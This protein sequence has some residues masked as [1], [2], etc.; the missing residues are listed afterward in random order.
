MIDIDIE[1]SLATPLARIKVLG[2]GGAGCNALNSM[3]DGEYEGVEF[4]ATNTDAQALRVCRAP[5][6]LQIGAKSTKGLGTGANPDLGRKAAE[7]DRE[8]ILAALEGAD[9]VFLVGG[10]GGGTGS[11]ALPVIARLLKEKNILTIA[12]VT[13]PFIFEGK[14][15]MITAEKSLG[16]LEKEVDTLVVIPNQWL[17][18][19][20]EKNVS[21]INA[22]GRVNGTIAQCV[23]SVADII[24]R[25]GQINVDFAD[26]RAIM[27]SQGTALMG[28]GRASGAN[29][30]QDATQAAISSSPLEMLSIAGARSV[31]LTLAGSS[32]LGLHEVSIAASIIYESADENAN[33]IMG[34]IID[35]S[36][37]DE[38]VVTIIATGFM[39]KMQEKL[40]DPIAPAARMAAPEYPHMA[41]Q[42]SEPM[43]SAAPAEQLQDP[44][45]IPAILRRL[46][47]ER[48]QRIR[49][50]HNQ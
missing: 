21:L 16:D 15:R 1:S 9:L 14:R 2:V 40:L 35:E 20:E 12:V 19:H 44:L 41:E 26:V 33:I 17:L 47:E 46:R 11:G 30:A 23:R 39:P 49:S 18:D 13:K 37:G 7:E 5:M 4:I 31:L 25:P 27:K 10:L 50:S 36:L 45:E 43:I 32:S 42:P 29:R 28:I 22:F 24:A 34:T 48:E 3:L 6:K 38:M 8:M